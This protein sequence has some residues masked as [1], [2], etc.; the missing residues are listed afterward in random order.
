M[1]LPVSQEQPVA[2][3]DAEPPAPGRAARGG[4]G[5]RP[6]AWWGRTVLAALCGL[7]LA[8]AFPPFDGGRCR[9]SR[10]PAWRC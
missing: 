6:R 1:A 3:Q 8:L 9:S 5:G 7:A 2:E 10:W 4:R